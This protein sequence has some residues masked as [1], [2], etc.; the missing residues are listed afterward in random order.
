MSRLDADI[1][2]CF[3]QIN[4][5]QLLSKINTFPTCRKQIKAWLKADICDFEKHG[6][7]PS[8]KGTPQGGVISPLLSN[9]ALHGMDNR[10]KQYARTLKGNKSKNEKSLTLIRYADDFVILHED[11]EVIKQCQKIIQEWLSQYDL[12]LKPEKTKICHTLKKLED[13][14]PGF[15]FLGFNIRQYPVGKHQSGK[16]TKGVPLGFKLLIKPSKESI[17]NH[18][19]SI[20]ETCR[21][22]NAAPQDALICKLNSIIR[23][24][25]NYYKTVVSKESFSKLNHLTFLRLLQWAKRRHP[26][27]P[28]SWIVN[29]YWSTVGLD[30]WVFGDKKGNILLNHPKT[31]I[32]RHIK[33]KDI[34]SPYDGD[35]LYWA[36]RKGKHPEL[37]SS[38]ARLLKLQKGKCNW[39]KLTFQD[40]D[41]IETDHITPIAMGEN[42]KDNL[43]LLH[44]HCHDNKTRYDPI[45]IK[46]HKVKK[47]WE[48][49]LKKFNKMNWIWVEDIPTL[50]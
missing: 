39:C 4:H 25:T 47:E 7:F 15:N 13:I 32:Q 45:A 34:K 10:I 42:Q 16:N 22:Y 46:K 5:S 12:K 23:G 37:K 33:V 48:K 17:K 40:G 6:T 21:R 20:A 31:K 14:E 26:K 49:T 1:A 29:K 38:T 30:N 35:T 8:H 19:D 28:I 9:I 24:W 3:D 2:K 41:I 50:I 36:T 11:L 27:K 43:Q 44:K 18:Y